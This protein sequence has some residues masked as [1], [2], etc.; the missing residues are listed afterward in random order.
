LR[1]VFRVWYPPF[2]ISIL[3]VAGKRKRIRPDCG[4]TGEKLKTNNI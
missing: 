4:I 1:P 2:L 3:P